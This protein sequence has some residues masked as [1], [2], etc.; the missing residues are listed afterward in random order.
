MESGIDDCLFHPAGNRHGSELEEKAFRF[1]KTVRL[2]TRTLPKAIANVEDEKQLVNPSGC[3]GANYI[4]ASEA[5]RNKDFIVRATISR[6]KV[7]E[8][9]YWLGLMSETNELANED[10]AH[11]LI[12]E[13]DELETMLSSI[14][15]KSKW[16]L[17]PR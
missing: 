1:S 12:K 8:S 14:I 9:R 2:F 3:V 5:L 6:K 11:T 16:T 10:T 17:G 4:E 7:K 15:Q 13:A